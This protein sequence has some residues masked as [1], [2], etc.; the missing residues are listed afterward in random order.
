[1]MLLRV[2]SRGKR[3][4]GGGGGGGALSIQKQI[5]EMCGPNL[6]NTPNSYAGRTRKPYIFH[7]I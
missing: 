1:M 6:E 3:G 2:C 5:D 7:I 4:G